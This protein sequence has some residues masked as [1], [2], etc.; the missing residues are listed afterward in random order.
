[1][2]EQFISE[3]VRPVA[4]GCD[5]AR[6]A[7]GEPGLPREFEWRGRRYA[8]ASV[9]AQWKESAPCRNGGRERYYRKHW[10]R[11]AATTGEQMKL[12]FERQARSGGKPKARWWLYAVEVAAEAEI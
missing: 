4:G 3:P 1:M 8:V 5:T 7:R 12:Y 10:W 6:M 2:S 9:L 11:I